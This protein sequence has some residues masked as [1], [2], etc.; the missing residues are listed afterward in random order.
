MPSYPVLQMNRHVSPQS[1]QFYLTPVLVLDGFLLDQI[2]LLLFNTELGRNGEQLSGNLVYSRPKAIRSSK[3]QFRLGVT[4]WVVGSPRLC[5][6]SHSI[7]YIVHYFNT[8]PMG[9]SP[10]LLDWSCPVQQGSSWEAPEQC[11][12]SVGTV[13]KSRHKTLPWGEGRKGKWEQLVE[14][15]SSP[16]P[17]AFTYHCRPG[18]GGGRTTTPSTSMI[19]PFHSL[20]SMFVTLT[21]LRLIALLL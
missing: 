10:S 18:S 4:E 6:K 5:P 9:C 8:S 19:G 17:P 2:L 3:L 13:S 14:G 21:L 15:C 7:P 11:W 16:T 12:R 20:I 1:F